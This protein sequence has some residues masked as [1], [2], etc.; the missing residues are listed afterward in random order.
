[1]PQKNIRDFH[2]P[3]DETKANL[4]QQFIDLQNEYQRIR[5]DSIDELVDSE[6]DTIQEAD[7]KLNLMV[8]QVDEAKIWGQYN[9]VE[10]Y[11][12]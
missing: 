2:K 7:N 10:N 8:S 9:V 4:L 5:S 6:Y 3:I 12:N 1:M 11:Q